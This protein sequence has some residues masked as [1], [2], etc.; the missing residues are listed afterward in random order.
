MPHACSIVPPRILRNLAERGDDDDRVRARLAL[1][2]SAGPRR[3]RLASVEVAGAIVLLP[4]AKRRTI[5]DAHHAHELPGVIARPEGGR[6]VRDVAVNE[7]Y[8]GAGR[9]YDFF[10]RVYGRSSVDDQGLR[11]ESTV[12]FGDGFNNAHWNGRQMIY[13]DG[14]GKYFNR[15]TSALEV[16]GH[17]LTHG[18]SQYCAAFAA[19]GQAGAL[20]EHFSDVFG[21]LVKQYA[22]R[23]TA[24]RA[25]WLVGE[26]L[27]TKRV[28][29]VAI[30]SMKAP[31]SAYDDPILGRD[32]QPSHMR[33]YVTTAS[34]DRG[35]HVNSGIPNHAFYRA[36][37]LLGGHAWDVAG[38]IWYHAL[39]HELGPRARFQQCADATFRA[40]GALYGSVSE[41]Q[42]AVRAAWRAVGIDVAAIDEP[43]LPIRKPSSRK[44]ASRDVFEHL[45]PGAEVPL[46]D[47]G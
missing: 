28:H 7:A 12:H 5:Y 45:G 33:D 27:F 22:L 42:D 24:A 29:G 26:G 20:A 8:D 21:V 18:V 4:R 1:T 36:A 40:A 9:T 16:I 25:N 30:R 11:L 38:R 39:A 31:G 2:L 35:V 34:D 23:Q 19:S 10:R 14:D 32:E 17:E 46:F 6:R 3:E 41:P 47:V 43:R 37:T 15:F 44:P 13:G